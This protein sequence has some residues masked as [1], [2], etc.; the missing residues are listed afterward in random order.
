MK[1][2]ITIFSLALLATFWVLSHRPCPDEL[3]A[4]DTDRTSRE[5]VNVIARTVE[6]GNLSDFVMLNFSGGSDSTMY[7]G[8]GTWDMDYLWYRTET[9][10]CSV[11]AALIT[12]RLDT[13]ADI[14]TTC[15]P[16]PAGSE[17]TFNE[18]WAGVRIKGSGSGT[19]FLRAVGHVP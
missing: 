4:T 1:T 10:A 19:I 18:D 14:D 5:A 12:G 17:G 15:M 3:E 16:V 13:S 11:C 7:W 2:K 8:D 9:A 6:P